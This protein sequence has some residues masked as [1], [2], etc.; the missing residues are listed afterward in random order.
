MFSMTGT[1]QGRTA[2]LLWKDG[3]LS[4][5]KIALDKAQYENTQEHGYLGAVPNCLNSNYLTDEL[6]ARGLL[7]LHVFDA[8]TREEN[9]DD[10]YNPNA[11]Y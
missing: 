2:S 10:P 3:I 9:D 4:G 7:R 6:P 8:I 5:D 1:V 11:V